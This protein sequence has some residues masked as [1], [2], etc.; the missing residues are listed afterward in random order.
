MDTAIRS[1]ESHFDRCCF[2]YFVDQHCGRRGNH[3]GGEYATFGIGGRSRI[4]LYL[5]MD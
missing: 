2:G 3:I 1:R 5:A 4:V